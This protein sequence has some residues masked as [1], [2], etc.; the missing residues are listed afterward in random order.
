MAL[1]TNKAG[2]LIDNVLERVGLAGFFPESLRISPESVASPKPAPDMLLLAAN[3]M[4]LPPEQCVMFGDSRNDAL[5][6]RAAGMPVVL[7]ET[8]YN[9]GEPI[10][11]WGAKHGFGDIFPNMS[12]ALKAIKD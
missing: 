5:A 10:N 8:G 4:E 3:R 12:E 2:V 11:A 6:A 9:E 1:V 7:L